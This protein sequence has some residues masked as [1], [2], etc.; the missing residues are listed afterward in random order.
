MSSERLR[1]MRYFIATFRGWCPSTGI[2]SLPMSI[3]NGLFA[4]LVSLSVCAVKRFAVYLQ[5][6][7]NKH[8]YH[9]Q[10]IKVRIAAQKKRDRPHR[11][12][13][14]HNNKF[15]LLPRITSVTFTVL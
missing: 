1:F 4:N 5:S 2:C 12:H 10:L 15:D 8:F 9:L 6:Q 11:R 13:A 7:I 3:V 14:L